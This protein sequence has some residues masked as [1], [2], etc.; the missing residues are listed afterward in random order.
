MMVRPVLPHGRPADESDAVVAALLRDLVEA[1][2]II[3]PVLWF[4]TPLAVAWTTSIRPGAV[5]YDCMD[6]LA[7][8]DFAA[9][10]LH[11]RERELLGRADVVFTGGESLFRAKAPRH[12]N[13]HLFPSAVDA[14]HFRAARTSQPDIAEQAPL[15]RPRLGW[16]GV[17]DER[18]DMDLLRGVAALRPQWAIVLVG[19]TVKI[20]PASIPASPN[21][22]RAGMR[23]YDELPQW[24]AG[25]DVAI[26]PF[27]RNA[28]TRFISP[29]KTLEYLAAGRPVVSTSIRDVVEPFQRL[30]LVRIADTPATFVDAV[31]DAL[32]DDLTKHAA[33]ADSFLARRTWDGTWS[34]MSDL[35][36]AAVA[37]RKRASPSPQSTRRGA[38]P[39]TT[40][41]R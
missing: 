27:A 2:E 17:I 39:T 5:V 41:R 4:S 21:V 32:A 1:Q 16:F 25:W 33:R 37:G 10:G 9:A 13:V 40:V 26:M 11:E 14:G 3:E 12:E 22:F 29:T 34:E 38:E 23:S 20:D 31:E 28:S 18:M 30:G 7:A 6:E 8:F 36:R 24:I 35:V 19:P 15:A